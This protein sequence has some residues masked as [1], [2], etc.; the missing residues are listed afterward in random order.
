VRGRQVF[1]IFFVAL[2]PLAIFLLLG[3]LVL[4]AYL[5]RNIFYDVEMSRYALTLKVD[6]PNPLVGHHHRPNANA[7]LMGVELRTNADGFRDDDY[8]VEKGDRRRVVFLGDS[9]TLGWGVDK[10]ETFEH[11]LERDLD[12]KSPTEILNLGVGNYN[13]TQ[14]LNLLIDKGLK[15]DPDQVVLFYFINDAEPVPAKSK[16]PGLGRFRIIT[17]FWSRVKALMARLSPTIGFQEYYSAL[18]REGSEGWEGSKAAFLELQRLS[19]EHGFDFRVVVLPELHE[20]VDYTFAAEHR[21]LTDFLDENGI[22]FLDLAPSFRE[23]RDPQSL[24][25]SFDDAH[26]NARAHRLIADYS[27]GFLAEDAE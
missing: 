4:R 19:G 1:E 18:Y 14:E 10:E 26:P 23:Q 8:P 17:F 15:Y 5:S 20:L 11:L 6:S 3:E 25:V 7:T 2:I 21:L 22:R 27:L 16:L 12:S 13:T 24:W 9:L